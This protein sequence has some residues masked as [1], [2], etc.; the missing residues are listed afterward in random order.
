MWVTSIHGYTDFSFSIKLEATLDWRVLIFGGYHE[1]V[2]FEHVLYDTIEDTTS[3]LVD[4]MVA[5]GTSECIQGESMNLE[6]RLIDSDRNGIAGQIVNFEYEHPTLG[7]QHLTGA[8]TLSDGTCSTNWICGLPNGTYPI[9]ASYGG[10]PGVHDA[11]TSAESYVVVLLDLSP[12]L[13]HDLMFGTTEDYVVVRPGE[14]LHIGTY[15]TEPGVGD[16]VGIPIDFYV[17]SDDRMRWT[18]IGTSTTIGWGYASV[19]WLVPVDL[20]GGDHYFRATYRGDYTYEPAVSENEIRLLIESVQFIDPSEGATVGTATPTF[21][22]DIAD[23]VPHDRVSFRIDWDSI[24]DLPADTTEWTSYPLSE[25]EHI[26]RVYLF[27]FADVRGVDYITINVDAN[28]PLVILSPENNDYVQASFSIEWEWQGGQPYD[29]VELLIDGS[30]AFSYVYSTIVGVLVADAGLHEITMRAWIG[31][32]AETASCNVIVD[33]IRPTVSITSPAVGTEF[34]TH[35]VPLVWDASDDNQLDRYEIIVDGSLYET[36]SN[37][38]TMSTTLDIE[39]GPHTIE[40][41]AYDAA[42]MS[43]GDSVDIIIKTSEPCVVITSPKDGAAL[44]SQTVDLYWSWY[45]TSPFNRFEISIDSVYNVTIYD[46]SAKIRVDEG[47]HN[48]EV[49][50][51]LAD[52]SSHSDD[53]EIE[54]DPT[55]SLVGEWDTGIY[56]GNA[57]GLTYAPHRDH[58]ACALDFCGDSRSEIIVAWLEY[59][60]GS[61]Y[62]IHMKMY[63]MGG[64]ELFHWTLVSDEDADS[65]QERIVDIVVAEFDGDD[66]DEFAIST[67]YEVRAFNYD[68]SSPYYTEIWSYT[69]WGHTYSLDAQDIDGDNYDEIWSGGVALLLDHDGSVIWSYNTVSNEFHTWFSW[70]PTESKFAQLDSDPQLEV[71]LTG[72]GNILVGNHDGSLVWMYDYCYDDYYDIGPAHYDIGNA[73]GD[74]LDEILIYNYGYSRLT[75]MDSDS[76]IIWDISLADRIYDARLEDLDNDGVCEILLLLGDTSWITNFTILDISGD[77]MNTIELQNTFANPYAW[78]KGIQVDN[79]DNDPDVE[80]YIPEYDR[81]LVLSRECEEE[82]EADCV[83]AHWFPRSYFPVDYD[84]DGS[85]ELGVWY[86]PPFMIFKITHDIENPTVNIKN[87]RNNDVVPSSFTI[88]W[89][90]TDN[91]AVVYSEVWANDTLVAN[92]TENIA[93]ITLTEGYYTIT[94]RTYD[95][96]GNIGFD[97]I[98]IS[99]DATPP[100]IT[101]TSPISRFNSSSKDISFTW[102]VVD[103][104]HVLV[105]LGGWQL[106]NTTT[107]Q[108]TVE[109]PIGSHNITCRVYDEAGNYAEDWIIV[110]VDTTAPEVLISNPI[111]DV[112]IGSNNTEVSW[113]VVE[114]GVGIAGIYLYVND[115]L[116][117]E[118]NYSAIVSDLEEGLNN[119]TIQCFDLAGNVGL[120]T[121]FVTVDLTNPGVAIRMPSSSLYHSGELTASV[122]CYDTS[123]IQKAQ[124]TIDGIYVE[125]LTYVSMVDSVETWAAIINT[126]TFSNGYHGFSFLVYDNVGHINSSSIIVEMTMDTENPVVEILKPYTGIQTLNSTVILNWNATDDSGINYFEITVNSILETQTTETSYPLLLAEGVH[127]VS[128][129]AVDMAFRESI[130]QI[131]IIVDQTAPSVSITDPTDREWVSGSIVVEVSIVES[132]TMSL[133]E[134]YVDDVLVDTDFISPWRFNLDVSGLSDGEHILEV[135]ATDQ[136]GNPGQAEILIRTGEVTTTTISTTV[137]T[138]PSSTS[139]TTSVS[140]TVSS[141]TSTSSTTSSTSTTPTTTEPIEEPT[142]LIEEILSFFLSPTGLMLIVIVVIIAGGLKRRG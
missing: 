25:G 15:A 52:E 120:D 45:S 118:K 23:G 130:D 60:P 106:T 113:T 48:I 75:L 93:H 134:L 109:L 131:T 117:G 84:G 78:W 94:V 103:K 88:N 36:I 61:D 24:V 69:N 10:D 20:E 102:D 140:S 9:R 64:A 116:V 54:I 142:N 129:K 21:T 110:T 124:V 3:E 53:I 104:D 96:R 119:I 86:A 121:L 108:I 5:D 87:P 135:I 100:A 112:L 57:P 101:I 137:T 31:D 95:E 81:V 6:A 35:S 46:V 77:M 32:T 33:R 71:L 128:V 41:V 107:D 17:S 79:I 42:Q 58:F 56:V 37:P 70:D 7:W 73:D 67:I 29:R 1:F 80:V 49:R 92:Q 47:I 98:D 40:V 12:L 39:S 76:S 89:T 141:T 26:V 115:M 44:G 126:T 27:L 122:E 97:E 16:V 43:T 50:G 105:L 91:N 133:A 18:Y 90:A 22:L 65:E 82:L 68:A 2:L 28:H 55:V 8:T 59:N 111:G 139:T 114:Y 125:Q 123:G 74:N 19:D 34:S 63:L 14:N 62:I 51:F 83:S 132:N 85:H 72:F 136:A 4:L 13:I 11:C 127:V 38:S 66:K 30:V 138:M 99:V